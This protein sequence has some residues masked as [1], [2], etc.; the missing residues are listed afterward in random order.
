MKKVFLIM[1]VAAFGVMTASAQFKLGVNVGI[2]S[3]TEK[4]AKLGYGGGISGEYLVTPNIGVGVNLGYYIFGKEGIDDFSVTPYMIP[5][6]LT[7][8]YY[9]IPEGDIKAYGGLDLGYYTIGAKTKIAGI[10]ASA[11]DGFFGVAPIVGLQFS[12]TNTLALDVNTK[13]SHIFSD[14]SS[15]GFIGINVGL[16][17]SF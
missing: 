13:Y 9:F 17:Y 12:F 2:Q 11:S 10:S 14:G 3:P 8:K 7:G 15:T 1:L 4:D 6:T 5:V 16:V